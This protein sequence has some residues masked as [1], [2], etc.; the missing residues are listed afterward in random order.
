MFFLNHESQMISLS[1]LI[2]VGSFFFLMLA[3]KILLKSS[4]S[5]KKNNSKPIYTLSFHLIQKT[6][7]SFFLTIS[8]LMA[9]NCH[10]ISSSLMHWIEKA[11][12]LMIMM[13]IG[14]WSHVMLSFWFNHYIQFKAAE[15][16]ANTTALGILSTLI[17][18][19]LYSVFCLLTLNL[20]GINITALIA[21]LGVGGIAVALAV[22]NILGDLFAS[23]TIVLDQ[24]FTVGDMIISG[25]C[26]GTVESIGLKTTRLRSLS[27]EQL[28]FP[29]GDLLK[30]H[31][32]N[33]KRMTE[34][35]VLFLIQIHYET[36]YENLEEIPALIKEV[37]LNQNHTRFERSC[38]K[39]YG[40]YSLEFETIYW[41]IAPGLSQASQIHEKINLGILKIFKAKEIHF[42]YPSIAQEVPTRVYQST[43]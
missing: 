40:T 3:K 35:R 13:Q 37:I 32:R 4:A 11:L 16:I 22:Q 23:L 6:H 21:G 39:N 8:F 26:Q 33:F 7:V 24:P 30:N 19:S 41:V 43:L 1:I 42:A 12:L 31:I 29:N 38:F 34:R 27:G 10:P 36:P 17:R 25:E 20:L 14:L 18:F 28:I 15:N 5:R 9:L 2:F